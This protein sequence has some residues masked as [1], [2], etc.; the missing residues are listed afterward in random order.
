MTFLKVNHQAMQT[1][2]SNAL[3]PMYMH[4]PS[5]HWICLMKSKRF[6]FFSIIMKTEMAQVVENNLIV[7]G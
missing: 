1:N 6:F 2:R 4:P 7:Y 3:D 5:W